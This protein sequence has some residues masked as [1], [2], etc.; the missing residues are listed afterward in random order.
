MLD[1]IFGGQSL[2]RKAHVHDLC[3]MAIAA[4]EVDEPSFAEDIDK[5]ALCHLIANDIGTLVDGG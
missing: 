3:R 4:G 2:Y 5:F 1:E